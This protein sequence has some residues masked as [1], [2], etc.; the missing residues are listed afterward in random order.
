MDETQAQALMERLQGV[1][2]R[3]ASQGGQDLDFR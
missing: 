2:F 3:V 1:E